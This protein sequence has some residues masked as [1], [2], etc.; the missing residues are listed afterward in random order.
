METAFCDA[1]RTLFAV[2]ETFDKHVLLF[3]KYQMCFHYPHFT[4]VSHGSKKQRNGSFKVRVP[5]NRMDMQGSRF[6]FVV[7]ASPHHCHLVLSNFGKL[8]KIY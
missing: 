5:D 6:L 2:S 1:W 4:R 3:G 7:N 8:R